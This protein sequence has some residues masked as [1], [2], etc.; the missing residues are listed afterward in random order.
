MKEEVNGKVIWN[1]AGKAGVILGL[2]PLAYMFAQM[3]VAKI[4]GYVVLTSLLNILLWAAK[5]YICLKVM[6]VAMVKF[7]CEFNVDSALVFRFGARAALCS[8]LI[9]AA[10]QL[11]N[12]LVIN[13]GMVA[14]QINAAIELYGAKLDANS[15]AA[16]DKVEEV[17][18][19]VTFFGN[20]IYCYLYGLVLS[21]IL[22]RMEPIT[23]IINND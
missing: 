11:A 22:S 16:L 9:V 23:H 3:G 17:F 14:E 8:A 2:V 1:E 13:P 12:I 18:P 6:H 20:L 10:G 7:A 21:W 15:L 19:S 4:E 5:F